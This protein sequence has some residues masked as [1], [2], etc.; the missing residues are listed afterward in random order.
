MDSDASLF[1]KVFLFW[2]GDKLKDESV[3]DCQYCSCLVYVG[4]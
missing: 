1:L 2:S 3:F 4:G